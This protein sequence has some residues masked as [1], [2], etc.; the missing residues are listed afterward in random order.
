[1][2][3]G[4]HFDQWWLLPIGRSNKIELQTESLGVN[5]A[6]ALP[7][8]AFSLSDSFDGP[9]VAANVSATCVA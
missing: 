3:C 8:Y 1:M 2:E 9:S 5:R 4:H 6:K 7:S